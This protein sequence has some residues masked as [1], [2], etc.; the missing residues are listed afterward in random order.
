MVVKF[1]TSTTRTTTK[2]STA[3]TVD[4]SLKGRMQGITQRT[5]EI[6]LANRAVPL[7]PLLKN[8]PRSG[9]FGTK[10]LVGF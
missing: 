3:F 5:P 8:I 10:R 9:N 7:N 1:V 2:P 6:R 4:V